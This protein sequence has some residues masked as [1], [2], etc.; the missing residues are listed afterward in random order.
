VQPR[1]FQE[2]IKHAKAGDITRGI[3]IPVHICMRT[4]KHTHLHLHRH[5]DNTNRTTN[6][7]VNTNENDNVNVSRKTNRN[8]DTNTSTATN[9]EHYR[10][11]MT[12]HYNDGKPLSNSTSTEF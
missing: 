12:L 9:D 3:I 11:E 1:K 7:N 2:A 6:T 10:E 8:I 5:Y 4:Y